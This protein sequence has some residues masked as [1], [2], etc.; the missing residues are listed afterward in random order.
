MKIEFS[1]QTYEKYSNTKFRENTFSGSR[2]VPWGWADGRT[3]RQ[4]EANS[5]FSNAPKHSLSRHQ[6]MWPSRTKI[7]H[8]RRFTAVR[9]SNVTVSNPIQL[10]F[11][12][13][14][15][16]FSVYKTARAKSDKSVAKTS[17]KHKTLEALPRLRQVLQ[18]R[19]DRKPVSVWSVMDHVTLWQTFL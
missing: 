15:V 10:L 2:A 1:W 18:L 14:Q 3:D 8:I 19:F 6:F 16:L 17:N 12:V 7:K 11:T 4:D 9:T 13:Q 5:P